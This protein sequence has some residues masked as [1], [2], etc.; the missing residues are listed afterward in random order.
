MNWKIIKKW[1]SYFIY[2]MCGLGI[3]MIMAATIMGGV[4]S[5]D[6]T[7][8]GFP[9]WIWANINTAYFFLGCFTAGGIIQAILELDSKKNK[10][11]DDKDEDDAVGAML[12]MIVFS[13]F[14]WPIVWSFI[15]FNWFWSFIK[16][17]KIEEKIEKKET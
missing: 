17:Q 7:L 6:L 2:F 15:F 8:I 13:G 10:T 4:Q 3:I 12:V 14:L 9:L 16:K 5:G 1:W 11:K